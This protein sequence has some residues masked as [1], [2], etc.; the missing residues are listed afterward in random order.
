MFLGALE[1]HPR[2]RTVRR[3]SIEEDERTSVDAWVGLTDEPTLV[4]IDVTTRGR[5]ARGAAENLLA[6]LRR[7]VI[8]VVVEQES[9]D[10]GLTAE[11]AFDAFVEYRRMG[12][13]FLV[14]RGTPRS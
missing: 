5:D 14:E 6:T 7:G 9:L 4:P 8:P 1:Q 3:T 11:R 2:V 10:R 13:R 12:D